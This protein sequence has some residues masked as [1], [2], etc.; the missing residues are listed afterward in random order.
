M[1]VRW[2]RAFVAMCRMSV[3]GLVAGPTVANDIAASSY[4]NQQK[5]EG[6]SLRSPAVESLSAFAFDT[7]FPIEGGVSQDS[8]WGVRDT[9]PAA[10][11]PSFNN[12]AS[13]GGACAGAWLLAAMF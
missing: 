8:F 9:P 11:T 6:E 3:D 7:P 12:W 4:T 2:W 5:E 13:S 10:S 1:V